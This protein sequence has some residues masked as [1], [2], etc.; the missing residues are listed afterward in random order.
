MKVMIN[1]DV[2]YVTPEE[3]TEPPFVAM[4]VEEVDNLPRE[5]QP[6]RPP[7]SPST[8]RK[9]ISACNQYDLDN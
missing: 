1:G 2:E 4:E 5:T 7:T 6:P 3:V 8:E 9:E